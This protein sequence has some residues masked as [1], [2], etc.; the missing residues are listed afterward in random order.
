MFSILE[1]VH[2]MSYTVSVE[3]E[4]EEEGGQASKFS[5]SSIHILRYGD[6]LPQGTVHRPYWSNCPFAVGLWDPDR[7]SEEDAALQAS[8]C[9][10]CLKLLDEAGTCGLLA[11][12]RYA[13]TEEL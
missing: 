3:E 5:L 11:C 4:E 12:R 6:H 9:R 13:V 10:E 7:A 2:R 8:S 1:V